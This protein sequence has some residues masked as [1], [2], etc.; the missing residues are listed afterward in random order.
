MKN[1]A[2]IY[3]RDVRN[4][5][6]NWAA[7]VIILGLIALP[8]LYAWFNIKA[9][10]D[11]YGNT[12]GIPI[13]VANND[14]GTTI[15]GNP[16]NLGNEVIDSLKD[17]HKLGWRFVSEEDAVKGAKHGKYYASIVI[18]DNFSATI[19]TVLTNNPTKA[20]IL[21]FVNEKIN[22][23]SPKIAS[24]GASGI[25]HEVSKNFVETANG[26]IFK[27]FNTLGIELQEQLPTIEKVRSL[28]FRLEKSFPE[29]NH[30]VNVAANDIHK[31]DQLVSKAKT[32]LPLVTQIA[33]NGRELA[34]SLDSFLAQSSDVVKTI[35]PNVK[36]DLL[37]LQQTAISAQE[38]TSVLMD[39]NADPS[40]VTDTLDLVSSRIDL[41]LK[42]QSQLIN[43]FDQLNKV[44][45]NRIGSVSSKLRQVQDKM[46]QQKGL[47][48]SISTTVKNGEKPAVDLVDR[49][50]QVSG[51][52]SGI[53]GDIIGRFDSE[54]EPAILSGLSKAQQTA[55]RTKTVLNDALNNVPDVEKILSDAS[56]GLT[57][58]SEG[59]RE[60]QKDLPGVEAKIT[61][62]TKKMRQFEAE[63]SLQELVNLLKNNFQLK[64]EFF[65]EP[66]VL[67][68][69][70]L[71]PIPNY[72]SAM[73]PFFS[74]L[75]LWVGATL[76]VSL[77]TTEIHSDQS[78]RNFEVY[79]GRFLIFLTIA[80]L[81]S[82][83]V[84]TGDI[85]LLG[86]YV[87]NKPWFI[88]FGMI[89][90]V[91]FILIVY[92]L[93]SVFGNV[94][95]ALAVVLLVLQLAGSG[96]TF[97]IQT[98]PAFFRAIHPFL[99][100]TYG[101]SMMRESVGGILWDIV[102]RDLLT[103]C[104]FIAITLVV[105]LALKG[106]INQLT[107]GLVKKAKESKLIH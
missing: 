25:I 29:I 20:E 51:D 91:V 16:I 27:I 36:Q 58:G 43:W 104:V 76:L 93:V 106:I 85:F 74:T 84:T 54:I 6:T 86:A 47:V 49:L 7:L 46:Q 4:I 23:I 31:S 88:I 96:G 2:L 14:K 97:P 92:T 71:Y 28:V 70:Q 53:L 66:V 33:E 61:E 103:M 105:G 11:P 30:V 98:T 15:R 19:A 50:N 87:V 13:A 8:S 75:A 32:D 44:T 48:S 69:N 99:P 55:A 38:L 52:I 90:S 22:A 40:V 80:L 9:S 5:V 35:A 37:L 95:K 100:F 3:G 94:G 83:L 57:L 101:I 82:I 56:K 67:K 39:T 17:N 26:T 60:I 21:Y 45:G 65:G 73:S 68:E 59:I 81:Q 34:S 79:L 24:S 18:P 12:G 62:L 42:V 64:S 41:G 72:G 78:Y 1:I 89:N 107:A 77:V 102:W 63:G 10:W